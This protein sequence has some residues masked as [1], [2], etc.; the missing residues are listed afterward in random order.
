MNCKI[1]GAGL[2]GLAAA[3]CLP[4]AG[5]D[6]DVYEQ[7]P[8]PADFYRWMFFA[9]GPAEQAVT[10]ES[11]DWDVPA[12]RSGQLGFGTVDDTFIAL[13]SALA[14]GPYVRGDR[15]TAVDV[16]PGSSLRW[17]MTFGTVEKR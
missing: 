16:Y 7:A 4:R 12:Q 6:V 17:G 13:E 11:M 14:N 15:F 1:V 5:F 10:V 2:D 8:E 3:G 9:A